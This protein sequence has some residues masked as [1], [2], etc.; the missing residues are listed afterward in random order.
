MKDF[1]DDKLMFSHG[2]IEGNVGRS[3]T[4]AQTK[5]SQHPLEWIGMTFCADINGPSLMNST[6]TLAPP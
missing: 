4:V 1:G 5:I 3:I 6:F 2:S